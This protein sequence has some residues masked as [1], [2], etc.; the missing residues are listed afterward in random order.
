MASAFSVLRVRLWVLPLVEAMRWVV[1]IAPVDMLSCDDMAPVLIDPVDMLSCD[2]MAPA[3]I[4]PV[5][6][7]SWAPIAPVLIGAPL[8]D[9]ARLAPPSARLAIRAA[10]AAVKIVFMLE[11]LLMVRSQARPGS[12]RWWDWCRRGGEEG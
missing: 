10:P 4:D 3:L 2:D 8:S 7:L 1:L 9:C 5:D 11:V 12:S 6:M